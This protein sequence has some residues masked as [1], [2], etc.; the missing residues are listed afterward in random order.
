MIILIANYK[1]GS[2]KSTLAFNL[3]L[4]LKTKNIKVTVFDL[5]PQK[6]LTDVCNIRIEDEVEPS[7]T[8]ENDVT[9]LEAC[10]LDDSIYVL[11]DVGVSDM[12]AMKKAISLADKIV[13]PVPP[14]QPDVWATH[15]FIKIINEIRGNSVP[16]ILAFIN[17]ADTH[18]DIRE[19]DEAEEALRTIGSINVL[20]PRLCQRTIF[21]RTLSEGLAVFELEKNSKGANEFEQLS[22]AVFGNL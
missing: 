5:D 21:R 18:K 11:V 16:K 15:R 3:S 20:T 2:G 10:A 22:Q 4:W 19:S 13:I 17:R 7:I 6:T 14:S 8:I 1:G 9:K 12:E